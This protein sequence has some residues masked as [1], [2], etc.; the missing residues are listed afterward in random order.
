LWSGE[1]ASET[2]TGFELLREN[3]QVVELFLVL[4]TQWRLIVPPAGGLVLY[5]GLDWLTIDVLLRR[6]RIKEHGVFDD[7]LLM[8]RAA[9]TVLNSDGS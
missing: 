7:L 2:P 1:E 6:R 5:L 3:R 4:E 9:L 8:E